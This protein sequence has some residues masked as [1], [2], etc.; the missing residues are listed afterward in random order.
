[1][2]AD[3]PGRFEKGCDAAAAGIHALCMKDHDCLMDLITQLLA[4][5]LAAFRS[6]GFVSRRDGMTQLR[7]MVNKGSMI[8]SQTF[9]NLAHSGRRMLITRQH[10]F[11][12]AP[13][14]LNIEGPG[15][16]LSIAWRF[17]LPGQV[18]LGPIRHDR[19]FGQELQG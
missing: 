6:M 18:H 2:V 17:L 1:M 14:L 19:F 15:W 9:R 12:C 11:Q 4:R 13:H 7:E 10:C 5:S 16:C 8:A 3:S